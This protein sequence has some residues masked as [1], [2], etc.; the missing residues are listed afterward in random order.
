MSCE[1]NSTV[2]SKSSVLRLWNIQA[3]ACDG[4]ALKQ[5]IFQIMT[6]QLGS[7][8]TFHWELWEKKKEKDLNL[9]V[10]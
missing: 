1:K 6:Q 5:I 3:G 4:G 10:L 2:L 9:W 8:T 7:F